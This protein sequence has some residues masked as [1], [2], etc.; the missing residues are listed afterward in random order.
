MR[1]L[2][3]GSLRGLVGT[4]LLAPQRLQRVEP[5]PPASPDCSLLSPLAHPLTSPLLRPVSAPLCAC[6]FS[7][8]A[9]YF[10]VRTG[11]GVEEGEAPG[12]P[13]LPLP[14][15]YKGILIFIVNLKGSSRP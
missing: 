1:D 6:K 9:L 4:F 5:E 13:L 7:P 8:S 15:I 10:G 11:G 14:V 2:A 3:P 12:D